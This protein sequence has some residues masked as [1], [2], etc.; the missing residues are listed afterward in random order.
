[1]SRIMQYSV[2]TDPIK[3]QIKFP[4]CTLWRCARDRF[5]GFHITDT[6]RK[7]KRRLI[8]IFCDH[9]LKMNYRLLGNMR[10]EVPLM[11]QKTIPLSFSVFNNVLT[12]R[13][14]FC[15]RETSGGESDC[16]IAWHQSFRTSSVVQTE[17]SIR[18]V[19]EVSFPKP[20]KS[21]AMRKALLFLQLF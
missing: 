19:P 9:G 7:I 14:I 8:S 12:W 10:K 6:D 16:D 20:S 21:S 3:W 2:S 5:D 17:A 18:T 15:V 1:M 11:L 13:R 4:V